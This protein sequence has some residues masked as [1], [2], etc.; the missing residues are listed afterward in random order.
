MIASVTF[1][2]FGRSSDIT[3]GLVKHMFIFLELI[4]LTSWDQREVFKN[5][6][7]LLNFS[8]LKKEKEKEQK[9]TVKIVKNSFDFI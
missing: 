6:L 2:N 5:Y 7:L 4:V 9:G 1:L 8:K 3:L